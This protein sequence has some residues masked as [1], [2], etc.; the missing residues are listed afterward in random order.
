MQAYLISD[1]TISLTN[2]DSVNY[3]YA[4]NILF[5]CFIAGH[6]ILGLLEVNFTQAELRNK[7]ML[8]LAG[9]IA[10]ADRVDWASKTRYGLAKFMASSFFAGAIVAAVICPAVFISSV[11][12]NE[13][14][15]FGYPVSER[16]DAVGQVRNSP[17]DT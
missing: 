2:K 12:I 13:I 1:R 10:Y 4:L 6:G 17:N 3:I 7:M 14:S 16:S 5:L 8:L 11:I 9:K 15:T